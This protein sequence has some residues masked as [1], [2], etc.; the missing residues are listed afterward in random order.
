LAL[1]DFSGT[2]LKHKTEHNKVTK[3]LLFAARCVT[4]EAKKVLLGIPVKVNIDSS[5]PEGKP[6]GGTAFVETKK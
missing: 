4:R 2:N 6:N 5:I 1:S 3:R